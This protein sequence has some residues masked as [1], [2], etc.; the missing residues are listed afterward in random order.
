[1]EATV[2]QEIAKQVGFVQRSSKNQ[3]DELI[4]LCVWL[5]QE[6]FVHHLC[7]MWSIRGFDGCIRR[8]SS[9]KSLCSL[10]QRLLYILKK[11]SFSDNSIILASSIKRWSILDT[12]SLKIRTMYCLLISKIVSSWLI[13]NIMRFLRI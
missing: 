7:K 4:S 8:N 2:L 12:L 13:S 3:A 5:S 9:T 11:I 10:E 6:S 1:M